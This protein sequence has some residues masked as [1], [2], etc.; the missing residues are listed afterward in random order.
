MGIM[1]VMKYHGNPNATFSC[2]HHV[3]G[4]V[5]W[6]RRKG[7]VLNHLEMMMLEMPMDADDADEEDDS[8]H[9]KDAL[10]TPVSDTIEKNIFCLPQ[11]TVN[12]A[13]CGRMRE[14]RSVCGNTRKSRTNTQTCIFSSRR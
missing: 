10:L 9:E 1:G 6:K 12:V 5:L 13:E 2:P 4:S 7:N 11:N 3:S 8:E 14:G